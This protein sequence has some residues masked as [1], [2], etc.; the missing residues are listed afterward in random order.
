M[1]SLLCPVLLWLT[2]SRSS[3]IGVE[4]VVRGIVGVVAMVFCGNRCGLC[5]GTE[6]L[7]TSLNWRYVP[8][9]SC[10]GPCCCRRLARSCE[11][12]LKY[13]Y[14]AQGG[15]SAVC[16]SQP[17]WFL[18]TRG[19]PCWSTESP[20]QGAAVGALLR[21][22]FLQHQRAVRGDTL[23]RHDCHMAVGSSV[24][25]QLRERLL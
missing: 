19:M 5:W 10:C 25:G 14:P 8:S 6:C 15:K 1:S 11:E 16:C 7:F 18:W 12:W 4:I 22:R 24:A 23:G 9:A 17:E 2:P 3:V 13:R 20:Q 21:C